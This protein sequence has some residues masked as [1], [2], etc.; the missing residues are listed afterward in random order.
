MTPLV[1]I[2]VPIYNCERFIAETLKST[3]QQS[4]LDFEILIVDDGS[5]DRSRSII[6][7]FVMID[8]RVKYIYQEN[9]GVSAA[10]NNGFRHSKG[11]YIAF[12]DSDDVWLPENLRTKLERFKGG[13]IGLVHSDGLVIDQ[14]SQKTETIL[15]GTE[16]NVL[17]AML[18]WRGTQIPGPSSIL[19]KREV[20]ETVGLFDENLSTAADKDLFIRIASRYKIA[21]IEQVTWY[22]RIHGS[23]MHKDIAT[24]ERD[25]L[26]LYRKAKEANLFVTEDFEKQCF[27]AMYLIL[28]ASW[29]GDGKNLRRSFPFVLRALR[30]NPALIFNVTARAINRWV[31]N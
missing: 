8:S 31:L 28:A 26:R 5:T 7:E 20:L 15:K 9:A 13:D 16:G 2:I 1:S 4:F 17:D 22:Y 18:L 3:I 21:R 29:A 10:R 14:Y 23:N 27:S 30:I 11:Q 19:V 6:N 12:L 25:I 24:M